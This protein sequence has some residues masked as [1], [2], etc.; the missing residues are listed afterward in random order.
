MELVDHSGDTVVTWRGPDGQ[1]ISSGDDFTITR[2][3]T[4]QRVVYSLQF[5]P[6]RVSHQG[7]YTCEASI[8]SV[9]YFDSKSFSLSVT[10]GR[11]R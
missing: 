6:L 5:N 10:P 2:Q 8:Q 4:S 1:S 7:Q 9:G 11:A 3:A